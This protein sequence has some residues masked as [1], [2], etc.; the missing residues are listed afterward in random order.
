LGRGREP[1]RGVNMVK[2]HYIYMKPILIKEQM[3]WC[4]PVIPAHRRI[5][6]S[7]LAWTP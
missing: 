1:E 5:M 7:K 2:I 4:T 6:S 3:W